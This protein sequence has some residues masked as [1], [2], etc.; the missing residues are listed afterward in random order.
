MSPWGLPVVVSIILLKLVPAV[1][2]SVGQISTGGWPTR[3]PP[4][5]PVDATGSQSAS[6]ADA[7]RVMNSASQGGMQR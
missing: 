6:D 5:G 3:R 4:K 7:P 2:I 1:R